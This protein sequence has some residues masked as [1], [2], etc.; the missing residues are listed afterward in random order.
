M[1]RLF[2][3]ETEINML[4]IHIIIIFGKN[5]IYEYRMNVKQ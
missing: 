4:S 2:C 5:D 1:Y 3:V